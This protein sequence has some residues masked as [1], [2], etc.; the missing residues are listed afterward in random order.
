MTTTSTGGFLSTSFNLG[1]GGVK[2]RQNDQESERGKK[3]E[4]TSPPQNG[5]R[6][7][8]T[9]ALHRI[10]DPSTSMDVY[11]YMCVY[12]YVDRDAIL[13]LSAQKSSSS[14]TP[15]FVFLAAL[16]LQPLLSF[17]FDEYYMTCSSSISEL[18]HGIALLRT[19]HNHC[20]G[21]KPFY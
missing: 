4:N 21:S 7:A 18:L 16:S 8:K 1:G 3:S 11:I 6:K 13:L 5:E 10:S 12:I 17:L 20:K 14:P 9:H 15:S 2:G 19:F